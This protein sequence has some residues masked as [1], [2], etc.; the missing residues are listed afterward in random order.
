M[1]TFNVIQGRQI[2][3]DSHGVNQILLDYVHVTFGELRKYR[4]KDEALY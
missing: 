3:K 4:L 1:F 2:S